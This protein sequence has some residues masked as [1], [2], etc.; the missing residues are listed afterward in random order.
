MDYKYISE[1]IRKHIIGIAH[2]IHK[3]PE[4]SLKFQE[5]F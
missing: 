4:L 2:A 1:D 3:N 5:R